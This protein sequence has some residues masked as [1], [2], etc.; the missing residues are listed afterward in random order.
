MNGH[1]GIIALL[2]AASLYSTIGW[3]LSCIF[4]LGY[5]YNLIR[6]VAESSAATQNVEPVPDSS[7]PV[8]DPIRPWNIKADLKKNIFFCI[9]LAALKK[10][11]TFFLD[12]DMQKMFFA[13]DTVGNLISPP[14]GAILVPEKWSK[15]LFVYFDH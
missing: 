3:I 12:K 14:G 11:S 6:T 13:C 1:L 15:M 7:K 5:S 8:R 2:V 4:T 9:F 10:F